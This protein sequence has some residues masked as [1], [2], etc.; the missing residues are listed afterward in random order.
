MQDIESANQILQMAIERLA[1]DVGDLI[2]EELTCEPGEG[3]IITSQE[4]CRQLR[5]KMVISQFEIIGAYAG[6]SYLVTGVKTAISLGGRLIMLPA[7]EIKGRMSAEN[8]DGELADAFNEV[9]NIV[10]GAF[11]STFTNLASGSL[12]FKKNYVNLETVPIGTGAVL[13]DFGD[14]S[15]FCVSSSTAV[16][17]ENIGPFWILLPPPALGL[18]TETPDNATSPSRESTQTTSTDNE[19]PTQQQL[20]L[21]VTED[22]QEGNNITALL[23]KKNFQVLQVTVNQDIKTTLREK[24]D[25]SCVFLVLKQVTDMGFAAT[26]KFRA[27]IKPHTPLIVAGPA[28]TKKSVLQAI[29][30]GACD[31]LITPIVESDLFDKLKTHLATNPEK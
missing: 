30:Y 14:V 1:K 25:V 20:V 28:W 7:H 17:G 18:V 8:V 15:Y 16:A 19:A 22:L 13:P 4:F 5:G 3:K 23:D 27:A 24:G 10:T 9:S 12:H 31:I 21:V 29:K 2:G 26:I 6:I 11:N